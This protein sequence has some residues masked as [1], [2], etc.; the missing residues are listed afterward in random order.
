MK[1]KEKIKI[2]SIIIYAIPVF[3]IFSIV[4]L[5]YWPGILVSDSM[6]Q[7]NQTQ[8]GVF[9]DWHPAY[10]TIYIFLLTK[11][12]NNPGFVLLVQCLLMAL[13][14]GYFF[15]RLEKY[16]KV[17]KYLL[18][19]ASFIF[20]IIPLNF[21]FAVTLLKDT[22]YSTFVILF[23][24]IIIDI[25]NDKEFFSNKIKCVFLL[26]VC[27]VIS[28]FRHNGI[29]VVA[30]TGI[31]LILVYRKK[32]MPYIVFGSWIIIYLLMTTIGFK[33]LNIQ[34]NS[35]ANK[36]GPVSHII[37]RM[38]NTD[39]VEFSSEDMEFL[40]KYV[41]IE[42]L[43]TTYNPY[44]MDYSINSQNIDNLKESGNE[45]LKFGIKKAIE[46][47]RVVIKHYIQLTSF[48]YSPIPFEGSYTVGMF[49]E[50]DLWIYNEKYP[51]LNEN[52]KIPNL[53]PILKNI[54]VK[55]Q[56]GGLG[57]V[58]MRPAIY[59]YLSI[60]MIII[61]SMIRK[62]KKIL[63]IILPTIINII[64][65]APAIP[66]AMTRYVYATMFG[67]IC[68]T[69]WFIFEIFNL[70]RRKKNENSSSNTMLQ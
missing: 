22:L 6:V 70:I 51:N 34:E 49:T 23:T 43:K 39:G 45:Y 48:L 38:L 35:Y 24:A 25:I 63:L 19:I 68:F 50:T 7:W 1:L 55:Y 17:N 9:D 44:N 64:S 53:L 59:M 36:Y 32:I 62:D 3:I 5:A 60:I 16:Y 30:L 8:T 27:L 14:I 33:I 28:L 57:I 18:F 20:A 10:N 21:N 52:S 2:P 61:I 42:K 56:T 66:V 37:A 29:I 41:D 46:Y 40:S 47:P 67:F 31:I 26:L 13:T 58:T 4:L 54:E 15:S 65:L 11:I 12:W 69:V